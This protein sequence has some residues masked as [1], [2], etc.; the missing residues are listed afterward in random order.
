MSAVD[1]SDPLLPRILCAGRQIPVA[2]GETV[3]SALLAHRLFIPYQ[4]QV[5]ACQT[6]I[7]R[8]LRGIPPVPSQIGLEDR[9]IAHGYFLACVAVPEGD[10]VV[11][12]PEDPAPGP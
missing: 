5:G 6:C 3:L 7:V 10:L 12:R 9:Q 4:C 11:L 2:P 8:C 1:R